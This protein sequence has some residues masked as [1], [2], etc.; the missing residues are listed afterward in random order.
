MAGT[1]RGNDNKLQSRIFPRLTTTAR[2][3]T[4]PAMQQQVVLTKQQQIIQ[5]GL[6]EPLQGFLERRY[7][8]EGKTLAEIGD[9]LD[10]RLST[11]SR[12]LW[13]FGIVAR[14]PGRRAA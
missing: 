12:W 7:V 5:I 4:F 6:G 1:M 9:E 11:V 10:I 2:Y 3:A 14:R 8:Q 13:Q